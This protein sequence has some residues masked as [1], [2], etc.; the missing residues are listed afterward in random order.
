MS[1]DPIYF[2]SATAIAKAI[3]EG[4]ISAVE[5]V[6]LSLRRIGEL[7]PKLNAV[8]TQCAERAI[9][10][11]HA[12]DR[13]LARGEVCGVLHGVPITIKDSIET[14]GIL[15]TAGTEGLKRHVPDR[16]ASVVAAL[17][18]AGAI[19]VGKSNT[20]ELTLS[21]ET[22]NKIFGRSNNPYDL[23]KSPGGSSG[24]AA[25]ILA[26]GGSALDLGSDVGGSI[27]EP[28]NFCGVVG[29]KPTS[30]RLP[31]TGHIPASY[32]V[33][34]SFAQIG[35]MARWIED[36]EL[37]LPLLCGC[38]W[39]DPKV[40]PMPLRACN[41]VDLQALRVATY[42]DNGAMKPHEDVACVVNEAA[43][44]SAA[45]GA[46]VTSAVPEA[47]PDAIAIISR[48]RNAEGG[49]PVRKALKLAGTTEPNPSL[50]YALDLPPAPPG[51]VLSGLLD[52]LD[53]IRRRMLLFMRDFDAIV[54]P[55]SPW[56]A[57]AHGFDSGQDRYA[58]WS[59]SMTYNLTGWPAVTVR[60]GTGADGLPVGVQ[61]VA[62]PWREDV[63]LAIARQ[64]EAALG[65]FRAPNL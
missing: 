21:G 61:V 50:A 40:I 60:A 63:A 1:M 17:R 32:G 9:D 7:N 39:Q 2:R 56:T 22:D 46:T 53:D 58:A 64:I 59:H 45:A 18:G 35:P 5:M 41:E 51:A 28:A 23:D 65:G 27:R 3:R 44:A 54:C 36:L 42:V 38:D 33:L 62:R 8:V 19:V 37:T 16:D 14:A 55:V 26:A 57:R 4:E 11:A 49:A 24:G 48:L 43:R 47:I 52:D 31:S 15:T 34:N 13:T 6:E 30:G 12:A 25:A 10:E 20:P 29:I